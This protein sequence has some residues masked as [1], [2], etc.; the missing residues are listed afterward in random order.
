MTIRSIFLRAFRYCDAEFLDSELSRI[1]EDFTKLGYPR[2]FID[3]AKISARKG[4]EHEK[5]VRAG[6][7]EPKPPRTKQPCTLVIP[8]HEKTR[9]LKQLYTER[10]IDVI[11]SSRD[12]IG[13]RVKHNPSPLVPSSPVPW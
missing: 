13:N 11:Y 3:K 1:Y 9:R 7:A 6:Q 2:R 4:R 8:Y 10:G 5:L 12:S